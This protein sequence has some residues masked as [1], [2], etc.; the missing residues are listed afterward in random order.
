MFRE[1][2]RPEEISDY[3]KFLDLI[4]SKID[5]EKEKEKENNMFTL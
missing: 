1:L 3:S 4:D 2:P 5:D